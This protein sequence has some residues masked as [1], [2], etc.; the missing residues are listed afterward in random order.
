M[1]AWVRSLWTYM[2]ILEALID[3][4]RHG[5]YPQN[6]DRSCMV[7]LLFSTVF[8]LFF[9]SF[10]NC[11]YR[12][13]LVLCADVIMS[14]TALKLL[15]P[16]ASTFQPQGTKCCLAAAALRGPAGEH[17]RA[18][19]ALI[20]VAERSET[21]VR[22]W[23]RGQERGEGGE[24]DNGRGNCAPTEVVNGAISP[25]VLVF[26]VVTSEAAAPAATSSHG[27]IPDDSWW[28]WPNDWYHVMI[29]SRK[30]HLSS[31]K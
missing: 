6:S 31:G 27:E 22:K 19:R 4:S 24:V 8:L 17:K 10:C 7:G 18:P 28:R 16:E 13:A 26:V 9:T 21:K 3:C 15:S 11:L 30:F 5:Q 1:V 25:F 12:N 2:Y 20:A 29:T 14:S 23:K